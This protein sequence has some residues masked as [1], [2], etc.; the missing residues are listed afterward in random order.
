MQQILARIEQARWKATAGLLSLF[1]PQRKS[2]SRLAPENIRRVLVIR[3]DG[4]GDAITSLPMLRLLQKLLP[5]AEIDVFCSHRNAQVIAALD[6]ISRIWVSRNGIVD[7]GWAVPLLR[8]VNYDL[9]ILTVRNQTSWHAMFMNAIAAPKTILAASFRGERYRRYFDF[10]SRW[11]DRGNNE[12]EQTLFLVC[13]LFAYSPAPEELEPFFPVVRLSWERA[14][15][16]L[17]RLGYERGNYTLVNLSAYQAHNRWGYEQLQ[18]TLD[19]MRQQLSLPLLACGTNADLKHYRPLLDLYGVGL[20]PPTP[21]I[22]EIAGIVASAR[23]VLTP[24]TGIVHLATALRTPVV[25]LYSSNGKAEYYWAPYRHQWA[26]V[27]HSEI[28]KPLSTIQ[29]PSIVAAVTTLVAHLNA[30]A[31]LLL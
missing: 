1:L 24:D 22:H 7:W 14:T 18:Q 5:H 28:G 15:Y 19:L 26:Y 25:A 3:D 31:V 30:S 6:G 21:D 8:R 12:W 27:V 10:H 13:E 4:L 11:A 20:Y 2:I 9:I 16:Q 17:K 29:P 23:C